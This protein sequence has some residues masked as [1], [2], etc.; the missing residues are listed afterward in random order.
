MKNWETRS[1]SGPDSPVATPMSQVSGRSRIITLTWPK[2]SSG[3]MTSTAFFGTTEKKLKLVIFCEILQRVRN[4]VF[5][6]FF[7]LRIKVSQNYNLK[8]TLGVSIC[9]DV[10]SIETLDL[11]VVKEWVSTASKSVS[12]QSRNLNRDWDFSILSRH[13]CSDQKVLIEI[14]KFVEI[15]KFL[16]FSTVC[17]NLDREVRGFLYFLVKISQSVETFYHF[18]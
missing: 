8:L 2:F 11:V 13:Q 5:S 4:R 12:W 3:D 18:Q 16:R 14:E 9:L 10:V 17:L 7:S 15:W 1:Q 6:I